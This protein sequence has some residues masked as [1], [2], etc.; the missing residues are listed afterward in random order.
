MLTGWVSNVE[1]P[2]S[3][4]LESGNVSKYDE[5]VRGTTAD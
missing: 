2:Q 5:R 3:P 4:V 1:G